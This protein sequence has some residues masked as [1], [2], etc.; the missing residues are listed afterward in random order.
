LEKANVCLW[1]SPCLKKDWPSELK[2]TKS[3]KLKRNECR[4]W[5][6]KHV[7][8]I[9]QHETCAILISSTNSYP[10]TNSRATRRAGKAR[11]KLAFLAQK[12]LWTTQGAW[13]IKRKNIM[14]SGRNLRDGQNMFIILFWMQEKWTVIFYMTKLTKLHV[15]SHGKRQLQHR[16]KSITQLTGN[17]PLHMKVGQKK[18]LLYGTASPKTLWSLNNITGHVKS[19]AKCMDKKRKIPIRTWDSNNNSVMVAASWHIPKKGPLK[20]KTEGWI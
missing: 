11:K 13:D 19:C 17:F 14:E 9:G 16:I 5:Q 7:T 18:C 20:C 4:E 2:N 15:L 8:A 1:E 6:K 3:I 12:L 10:N